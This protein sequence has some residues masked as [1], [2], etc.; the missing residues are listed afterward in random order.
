MKKYK[1]IPIIVLLAFLV[2]SCSAQSDIPGEITTH[3]ENSNVKADA[4][5]PKINDY[6]EPMLAFSTVANTI[7][8]TYLDYS[9]S[10]ELIS[11]LENAKIRTNINQSIESV[12]HKSKNNTLQIERSLYDASSNAPLQMKVTGK[13]L[14]FDNQ[15]LSY[16]IVFK[17]L[18]AGDEESNS[19]VFLNYDLA[20][21][22]SIKLKDLLP[23]DQFYSQMEAT[24]SES[25]DEPFNKNTISIYNLNESFYF[26]DKNS[27]VFFIRPFE[28]SDKQ[29]QS[30]KMPL[31]GIQYDPSKK[32]IIGAATINKEHIENT[33]FYDVFFSYP[34]FEG[35]DGDYSKINQVI[36]QHVNELYDY[37]TN[38]AILDHQVV[39][40][41]A[42][43]DLDNNITSPDL[44]SVE[45][46]DPESTNVP[47]AT[48]SIDSS[49]SEFD[50]P[51]YWYNLSYNIYTNNEKILS[52]GLYDYQYTGG[53]HG[54]SSGNFYSYDLELGKQIEIKDLFEPKFDYITYINDCIYRKI[55]QEVKNDP[56]SN[57]AYYDFNGIDENIKFYIEDNELVIFFDQYEIAPYA[58]GT[59]TFKISLP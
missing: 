5:Q 58:A 17:T 30:I 23:L 20:S 54:L 31:T 26:S 13:P 33:D 49:A 52:F 4:V 41:P 12:I 14:Y 11:N 25:F 27:A 16:E 38:M 22:Q 6:T 34:Y 40:P 59:P 35:T 28:L 18:T 3:V 56:D 29:K 10:Y 44:D 42:L 43:N 36:E 37:G 32:L 46:S 2:T 1:F 24:H 47:D 21:G 39:E 9:E 50:L 7:D 8:E 15:V 19:Y 48:E 55:D 51:I 57:Y 53:A 45:T